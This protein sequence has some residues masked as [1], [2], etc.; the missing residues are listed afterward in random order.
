VAAE[1][2]LQRREADTAAPAQATAATFTKH[3]SRPVD[4]SATTQERRQAR[5]DREPEPEA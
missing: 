5:A 3:A 1:L 2:Q 4:P